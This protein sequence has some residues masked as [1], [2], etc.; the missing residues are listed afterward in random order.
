MSRRGAAGGVGLLRFPEWHY[1]T[2]VAAGFSKGDIHDYPI[3]ELI[4]AMRD[5][6]ARGRPI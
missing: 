5:W 2:L 1:E 3:V 4:D 6:F